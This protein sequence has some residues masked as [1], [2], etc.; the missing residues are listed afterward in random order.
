MT[1]EK[2]IFCW[3][4]GKDSALALNRIL[5]EGRFEVT[6]RLTTG[7]G[8]FQRVFMHG[9][10]VEPLEQPAAALDLPQEKV[11][12]LLPEKSGDNFSPLK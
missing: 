2:S 3:S 4:G 6:T 11:S 5:Q 10:R 8:H 7:T 12:G 9:V 1:K